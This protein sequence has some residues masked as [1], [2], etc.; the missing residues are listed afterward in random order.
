MKLLALDL[1]TK[2]S[3]YA[4]FEDK[5]LTKYGCI[6][7]SKQDTIERILYMTS[8]IKKLLSETPIDKVIM[9]EVIPKNE[10]Y[11]DGASHHSNP[12]VFKPLMWLQAC[13]NIMIHISYKNIKIDFIMPNSWR[14]LCGI[15]TGRGITRETLKKADVEFAHNKFGIVVN[16]DVADACG[17][18]WSVVGAKPNFDWS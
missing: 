4:I 12:K 8:E 3:G 2:S 14:S 9:E 18:G 7:C 13:V 1:S 16:D 17:I 5:K 6:Q 10:D 15:H 11:D